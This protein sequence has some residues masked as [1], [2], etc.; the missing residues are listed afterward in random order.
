MILIVIGESDDKL[1]YLVQFKQKLYFRVEHLGRDPPAAVLWI[2]TTFVRIR[3]YK[4]SVKGIVSRD[5]HMFF[6]TIR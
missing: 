4:S 3:L 5:L 1:L 6:D 2:R